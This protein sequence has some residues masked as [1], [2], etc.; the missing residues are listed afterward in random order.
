[1]LPVKNVLQMRLS[2]ES[3][4]MILNATFELR[5]AVDSVKVLNQN[6]FIITGIH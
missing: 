4:F 5:V 1:M 3:V 6:L 2:H